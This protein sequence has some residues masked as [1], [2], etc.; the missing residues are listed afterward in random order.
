MP[1]SEN[2]GCGIEAVGAPGSAPA[3]PFSRR[4]S[5]LSIQAPTRV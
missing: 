1:A 4:G 5:P 3:Q 2:G